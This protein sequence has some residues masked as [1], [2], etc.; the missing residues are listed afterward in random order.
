M[1]AFTAGN[2]SLVLAEFRAARRLKP[3][4][5]IPAAVAP[6]GHPLVTLYTAAAETPEQDR[7]LEAVIPPIGSTVAVDGAQ[8][9]LRLHGLSA[10]VQFFGEDDQLTATEYL[11]H[12]DPT[13]RYG[14]LPIELAHQ[15]RRRRRLLAATGASAL[16]AGGL[17]TRALVGEQQFLD[18]TVAL[19]AP[20][21]AQATNNAFFW[22]SVGVSSVTVGLGVFTAVTW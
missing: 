8:G 3:G 2:E 13:P 20:R 16:I 1:A 5:E 7:D 12:S 22:S 15:K 21:E 9:G 18:T 4:Y 14:P 19:P 17:Y 6:D 10:I 11:L